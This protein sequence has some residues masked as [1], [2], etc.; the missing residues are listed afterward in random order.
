[1]GL[2]QEQIGL[3]NITKDHRKKSSSSTAL[4]EKA[5]S[6]KRRRRDD[7]AKPRRGGELKRS[8]RGEAAKE[9]ILHRE[10]KRE[11]KKNRIL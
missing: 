7:Y 4:R 3:E 5:S 11:R 10:R 2:W 6:N 9:K 1:V 8:T